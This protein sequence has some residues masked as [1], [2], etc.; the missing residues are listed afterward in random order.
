M[1][2]WDVATAVGAPWE[3]DDAAVRAALE[4]CDLIVTPEARN[5]GQFGDPHRGATTAM[6]RLLAQTGRR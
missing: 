4:V 3:I 5:T 1:H 2:G 6:Q